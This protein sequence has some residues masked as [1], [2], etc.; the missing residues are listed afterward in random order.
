MY[1]CIY[2]DRG[3]ITS[4]VF[5]RRLP[6]SA[7]LQPKKIILALG[8]ST[9][10]NPLGKFARPCFECHASVKGPSGEETLHFE[11]CGLVWME[12]PNVVSIVI[13]EKIEYGHMENYWNIVSVFFW[14]FFEMSTFYLLQDDLGPRVSDIHMANEC[15]PSDPPQKQQPFPD[16]PGQSLL[17]AVNHK[18]L[19]LVPYINFPS[20]QSQEPNGWSNTAGWW[21]FFLLQDTSWSQQHWF[22]MALATREVSPPAEDIRGKDPNHDPT[23][24]WTEKNWSHLHLDFRARGSGWAESLVP[25]WYFFR[26]P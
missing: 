9:S 7:T 20:L 19:P 16:R 23:T 2:L 22:S 15:P 5:L 3:H 10:W 11:A 17:W 14:G 12:I 8:K 25:S 24:I 13:L 21:L 26:A 18:S 4:S 6:K 1:I